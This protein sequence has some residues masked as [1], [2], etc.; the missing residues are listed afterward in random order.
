MSAVEKTT[1]MSA[2]FGIEDMLSK[3]S[4]VLFETV[5]STRHIGRVIDFF[6]FESQVYFKTFKDSAEMEQ[7]FRQILEMGIFNVWRNYRKTETVKSIELEVGWDKD[8]LY[9]GITGSFEPGLKGLNLSEAEDANLDSLRVRSMLKIIQGLSDEFIIRQNSISG[10]I[11]VIAGLQSNPTT[12]KLFQYVTVD[13]ESLMPARNVKMITPEALADANIAGFVQDSN[14]A[15]QEPTSELTGNL[16]GEDWLVNVQAKNQMDENENVRIAGVTDIQ[17]DAAL[18]IG[19]SSAL[20]STD[21]Q[22]KVRGARDS[23]DG[24]LDSECEQN[25]ETIAKE[26]IQELRTELSEV[27]PSLVQDQFNEIFI[28]GSRAVFDRYAAEIKHIIKMQGLNGGSSKME[29]Q[30][31][32][33]NEA[34]Q[35]DKAMNDV[36]QSYTKRLEGVTNAGDAKE[37]VREMFAELQKEKGEFNRKMRAFESDQKKRELELKTIEQTLKEQLR[38]KDETLRQKEL[39]AVKTKEALTNALR[40]ISRLKTES[41]SS[42]K[43]ELMK[44]LMVSEKLLS[45]TKESNEKNVKRLEDIQQRWIKESNERASLSKELAMKEKQIADLQNR[46]NNVISNKGA[47]RLAEANQKT[48]DS[49]K[50]QI[51]QLQEKL[52]AANAAVAKAAQAATQDNKKAV[53]QS[54]DNE[55]KHKL[56]QTNKI[57]KV[58]KDDNEKLK[59]KSEELRMS[60][61]KLKVEVGK[62]QAQIKALLKK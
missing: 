55:S 50:S 2:D 59:K 53:N 58:M 48:M 56:E 5:F 10:R 61:T 24:S 51:K 18:N 52:A 9:I 41:S 32:N 21:E 42:D 3:E 6:M 12:E 54:A 60:E 16:S 14:G 25:L 31:I 23:A 37:V 57:L 38:R 8:N 43:G 15:K 34:D 33:S 20:A 36:M 26:V 62:L 29:L 30:G 4:R 11:Q 13:P 22:I 45:V 47:D 46:L 39:S 35:A 40:T 27:E 7:K 44:K 28:E 17:N 19:G 49:L 1:I